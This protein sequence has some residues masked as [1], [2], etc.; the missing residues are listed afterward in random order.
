MRVI[1]IIPS[2]FEYFGDIRS[3]AFKLLDGLNKIGVDTEAFTL[4][5]GA[6][7]KAFKDSVKAD[8]PSVH[9]FK[10]NVGIDELIENLDEF[11]IVH[12][13]CPFL[14]A[15]RKIINWKKLNPDFP[16]VV[17]YYRDVRF[18][19]LFSLFIKLYNF[20][21]LRKIFALSSIVIC[22]NFEEFQNSSGV[23]YMNNKSKLA[24]L[25]EMELDKETGGLDTVE[26]V[27]VKTLVVYNSLVEE[28]VK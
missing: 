9:D 27:A 21:F 1:H 15:A 13:H 20:Y 12:L 6:P 7:S 28:L 22:R 16:L 4:Q 24:V 10:G 14:G 11:D 3:Q 5:Y 25:D 2:A 19:D 26:A 8:S 18:D 23:G 17:T